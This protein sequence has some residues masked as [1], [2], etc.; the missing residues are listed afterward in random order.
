MLENTPPF[1]LA[2]WIHVSGFAGLTVRI[3]RKDH[4]PRIA[5]APRPLPHTTPAQRLAM[6]KTLLPQGDRK[7]EVSQILASAPIY[8]SAEVRLNHDEV[9]SRGA[10]S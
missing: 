4:Q 9:D 8:T 7:R 6:G 3:A 10:K 5:H 2:T 1:P